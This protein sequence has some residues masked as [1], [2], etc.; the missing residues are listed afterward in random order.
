MIKKMF[1]PL[2]TVVL[3]M[4]MVSC[5]SQKKVV[6]FQGADSV[7]NE[8]RLIAEQYEMKIKPADNIMIRINSEEPELL[9]IFAQEVTI[10]MQTTSTIQ[11][12]N[13]NSV[14]GYTVDNRGDVTLPIIG[15][16]HVAGMGTEAC[17]KAIEQAIMEK[18]LIEKPDITVRLMN[19]RVTIVG[20]VNHPGVVELSSERNT[21]VDVLAKAGD[22]DDAGLRKNIRLFREEN[23]TRVMYTLDITQTDIFNSPAYYVQQNDMIY[24]QPN[25]SK[26]VRSSTFYTYLSAFGGTVLGLASTV[27]SVIAL[28]NK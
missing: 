17:A 5:V 4:S 3:V 13:V 9:R 2:L 8:A 26:S 10:G 14:Y 24:V 23:G 18:R 21:I 27:I 19:A 11:G 15:T 25:R 12:N 20:A 16:V 6:Y 7:Y 28:V 22:I 1:L